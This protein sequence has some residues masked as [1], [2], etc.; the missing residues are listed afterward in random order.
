MFSELTQTFFTR[1][2][3]FKNEIGAI[4]VDSLTKNWF[5]FQINSVDVYFI[6]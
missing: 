6:D 1:S 2:C 5:V 3:C 4:L